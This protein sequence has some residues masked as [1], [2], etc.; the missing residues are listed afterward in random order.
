MNDATLSERLAEW[1][2]AL[3]PRDIPDSMAA[4]AEAILVDVVGLCLAARN[5]DY[6][7]SILTAAEPG[8]HVAIG[9]AARLTAAD[10]ALVN[11]TAAHGED[12]DDTFEGG[13]VH[14]GAVVVPAVL[15]VAERES[16]SG[17]RVM[18][19]ISAGTELLCRLGLVAPKAIHKA[20]FHPTAVLGSLAAAF[21]VGVAIGADAKA[22][23]ETLGIAGSTASGIIEYLGDGSST[24]RMHAG[25]AAQSGMRAAL[26]G[27]AGFVGPRAVLEGE[28]GFFRAFAPSV[29]PMFDR[30]F[31]DLGRRWIAETISFKPYP[32]GTMVQPYIDCARRLRDE[33]VPG[34]EI[35]AIHCATSDGYV[36]RLWEP[37]EM[38][39]NPPTDYAAK[40]SIPFGVALGLERGHAGLADFSDASIR[41]EA[42][43]R[44]SR[45]VTYEIDPDDPYPARFTGHVRVETRDGRVFEA[46]QDHMRGGVDAPLTRDE[47]DQKFLANARYGGIENPEK[48]LALCGEL[49]KGDAA[50]SVIVGL[51]AD[52]ERPR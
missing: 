47:V 9:H 32:C 41:D 22:L 12:F 14:S 16:L 1:G 7:G 28:H 35:V 49:L 37:L 48:L 44:L 5:T 38:K 15:A 17:E 34:D 42:L 26:M 27:F 51:A 6:I 46:S 30:L 52:K 23:K 45:L 4:K 24:K 50:A 19:G 31:D 10:A 8:R 20:G 36:H 25:W 39:R 21:A 13:P 33:G 29:T 11:G 18:L 43:L 3:R 40:F 2:A